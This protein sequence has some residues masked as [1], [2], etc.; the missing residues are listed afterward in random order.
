LRA[1][2]AVDP[3][4]H[5][6]NVYMLD[7]K[8]NRIDRRNPQDIFTPLY[9]HQIPPGAARVVHYA[10]KV[11]EDQRAPLTVEAKLQYRKFDTPYLQYVFG[12]DY[13]NDLPITT[14]STD[15]I[16]FPIASGEEAPPPPPLATPEWQRWNDYGIALLIEGDAGSEK[17]ELAQ[18]ANAFAEVEKLG[19]ADGPLNLA[20]AYLKEGRLDDAAEA[21][22]RALRMDPPAPRWTVAWLNGLVDK[23]N[24]FLDKAISEFRSVLE[25]R[26]PELDARGLDFSKDYEVINELGQTLFESAKLERGEANRERREFFLRQAVEQFERTLALDSENVS[27]HYNLALLHRQL[28]DETRE[29][30]HRKLHERFRPDDNARDRAIELARRRDPAADRAAQSITIYSLHRPGAPELP[31]SK[32]AFGRDAAATAAK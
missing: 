14:I 31:S 10:L 7:R 21:L 20:R 29:Q 24:G 19:K 16:T 17:G 13:V 8:G 27:A 6:V 5:F 30:E 25:D 22:R 11:P 1:Q 26:Y 28:G 32:V 15:R 3:Y 18:A 23:Q 2:R 12:R 4:A 9:N